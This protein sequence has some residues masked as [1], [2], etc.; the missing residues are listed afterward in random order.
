MDFH[1]KAYVCIHVFD[2][3]RP[4]L[5]VTRPEGDWCLLC[6][7]NHEDDASA[8]RVVGIGHVLERDGSLLEVLDLEPSWDAERTALGD[9]WLRRPIDE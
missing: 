5:L 4:V 6:G 7:E 1:Q 8:Y 9:P 3:V 2:G